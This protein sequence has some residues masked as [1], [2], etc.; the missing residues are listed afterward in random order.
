LRW[1][2]SK[3]NRKA[4]SESVFFIFFNI[5]QA[6]LA[7]GDRVSV[8]LLNPHQTFKDSQVSER[9]AHRLPR[10]VTGRGVGVDGVDG[11]DEEEERGERAVI[12]ESRGGCF[13]HVEYSGIAASSVDTLIDGARPYCFGRPVPTCARLKNDL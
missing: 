5:D 3:K 4:G 13:Y 12:T 10:V 1:L 11:V 8:C 7:Q 6:A 9:Q 2:G